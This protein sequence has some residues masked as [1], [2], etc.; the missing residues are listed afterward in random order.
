MA[1]GCCSAEQTLCFVLSTVTLQWIHWHEKYLQ[2]SAISC[3]SDGWRI[4]CR[5]LVLTWLMNTGV[6]V[7]PTDVLPLCT[8]DCCFESISHEHQW[9]LYVWLRTTPYHPS[10]CGLDLPCAM[11][12]PIKM[13]QCTSSG[14]MGRKDREC[15]HSRCRWCAATA[16]FLLAVRVCSVCKGEGGEIEGLVPIILRARPVRWVSLRP[17][18]AYNSGAGLICYPNAGSH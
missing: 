1:T 10:C 7:S 16:T 12:R 4:S 18:T 3:S 13:A 9:L 15:I 5:T 14:G 17:C 6:C 8:V 2:K 11:L